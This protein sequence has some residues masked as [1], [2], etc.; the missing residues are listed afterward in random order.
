MID[1]G[2]ITTVMFPAEIAQTDRFSLTETRHQLDIVNINI[3][4]IGADKT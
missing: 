3:G 1:T 2:E 4:R